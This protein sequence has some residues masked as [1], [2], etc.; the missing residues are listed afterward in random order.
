MTVVIV[1]I[2]QY[3]QMKLIMNKYI[4]ISLEKFRP[5][6]SKNQNDSHNTTRP[7]AR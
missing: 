2:F 4:D 5:K 7:D 6:K 1:R 3:A